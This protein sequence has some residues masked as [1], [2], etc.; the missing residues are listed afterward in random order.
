M[1]PIRLSARR[2]LAKESATGTFALVS[3]KRRTYFR[4]PPY[5]ESG[6][7]FPGEGNY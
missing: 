6:S 1:S 7:A 3:A 5:R 4:T 2:D